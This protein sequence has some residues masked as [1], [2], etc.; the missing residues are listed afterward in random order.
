MLKHSKN[1]K[2]LREGKQNRKRQIKKRLLIQ[3]LKKMRR[4]KR[5][6]KMKRKSNDCMIINTYNN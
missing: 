6:E 4:K 5:K 1:W 3:M 2:T